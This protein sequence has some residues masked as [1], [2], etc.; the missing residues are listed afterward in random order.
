MEEIIDPSHKVDEEYSEASVT[1]SPVC[2]LKGAK[3][4]VHLRE[5]ALKSLKTS[6]K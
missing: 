4:L 1:P 2:A 6:E 3:D 5:N